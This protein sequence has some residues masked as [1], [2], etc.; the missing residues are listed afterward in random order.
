[1]KTLPQFEK[2]G[3]AAFTLVELLVSTS[4][5]ALLMLV[6]VAM[7]NQTSQT[8]RYTTEKIE[9]FQEARDGFE[10]M[11]RQISQATLNT[12]W[13]YLD[14]T[15]ASRPTDVTSAAY[16]KFLPATYGRRSELRFISGPMALGAA[17][18]MP[19]GGGGTVGLGSGGFA[20]MQGIFFQ[21]PLGVVEN[22]TANRATYG[23]LYSEMDNLLNTW[24]YFLEVNND[25][26]RPTFVQ[27]VSPTRW[28]SRL[29]EFRQPCDKMSVYDVDTTSANPAVTGLWYSAGMSSATPPT[30]V[31]AENVVSL[32]VWPRL[33]KTEEETRRDLGMSVLS[34]N[35]NYD[36]IQTVNSGVVLKNPITTAAGVAEA[37]AINPKNQLPPIVQITMVAIDERSAQRLIDTQANKTDPTLG[38]NT[39]DLFL[40]GCLPGTKTTIDTQYETDLATLERRLVQ[41]KLTYRIFSTNVSIRGAKWSRAQT[42]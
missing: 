21:A 11:T 27:S 5:I 34:P 7:T 29:M 16:R 19:G 41:K 36:S 28:R 40:V 24:G 18:L 14:S 32:I 38:L 12:Y 37:A 2:L 33:S 3:R 42:K 17:P 1:M 31:L 6:L 4:I 25:A 10:A 23:N 15:G 35:Y 26:N 13:D 39:N 8:W 22:T 9:K 30:R 20:H